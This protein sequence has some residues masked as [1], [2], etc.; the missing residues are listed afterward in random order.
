MG[1]AQDLGLGMLNT[2]IKFILA[3]AIFVGVVFFAGY[4]IGKKK[5][6]DEGLNAKKDGQFMMQVDTSYI[7]K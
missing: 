1:A 4:F 7:K 2:F 3:M 5:G 6:F